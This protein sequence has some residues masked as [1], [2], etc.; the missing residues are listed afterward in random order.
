MKQINFDRLL[1]YISHLPYAFK[2][3]NGLGEVYNNIR[4]LFEKDFYNFKKFIKKYN[5]LKLKLFLSN[6]KTVRGTSPI[7]RNK[8]GGRK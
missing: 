6:K 1:T 7:K 2:F 8:P 5:I 4:N 3:Y